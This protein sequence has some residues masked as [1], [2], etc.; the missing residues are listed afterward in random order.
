MVRLPPGYTIVWS[1]Q[2]DY[3]RRAKERMKLVIPATLGIVFLL[4]HFN[5]RSVGERA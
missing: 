1:G 2:Y 4:L 3:M 5:F